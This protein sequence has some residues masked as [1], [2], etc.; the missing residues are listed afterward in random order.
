M[1]LFFTFYR[2]FWIAGLIINTTCVSILY[3]QGLGTIS[4]L[5]WFKLI[6]L[7]ITYLFISDSKAAEFSYYK[8]LGI[9]KQQLW[10]F[11]LVLEIILFFTVVSITL[12]IR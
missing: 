1:R 11:S 6:T 7:L 5:F 3:L 8:N 2:S 4:A 9:T 12:S 10:A